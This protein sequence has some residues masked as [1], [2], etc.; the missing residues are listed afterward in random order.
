MDMMTD[1]ER[2]TFKPLTP[3][4]W[5]DFEELFGKHGACGGCWCMW[6]RLKRSDFTKQKGEGNKK[7]M[8]QIVDSGEIPGILAY[9]E[10]KAIGWCS[11][12]PREVFKTLERSRILRPVDSQAVWSVVCF[13]VANPF[14]RKGL[15]VRL[16]EAAIK[17]VQEQGGKIVE[18]Y[19]SEPGMNLPDAFVYT[20]LTSAF[21]KAGFAEALRRSK[22][23]P[24]M[25]H[26]IGET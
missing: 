16:L 25:R 26:V 2:I 6:W 11:V 9:A 10:N 24:I 1:I 18:G 14:R 19:P 20:G 8:K 22:K 23:R 17:H 7:A 21:R 13:F 15:T 4:R 5:G 12:G 3:E